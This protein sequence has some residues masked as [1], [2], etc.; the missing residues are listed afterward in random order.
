MITENYFNSRQKIQSFLIHYC[1]RQFVNKCIQVSIRHANSLI[2]ENTIIP[3]LILLNILPKQNLE[4]HLTMTSET[5]TSF[6]A[7]RMILLLLGLFIIVYN[8]LF[9]SPINARILP[10]C[11]ARESVL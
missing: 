5:Y 10:R 9:T 8:S 4:I 1:F 2:L 11:V 7:C 3:F 6:K